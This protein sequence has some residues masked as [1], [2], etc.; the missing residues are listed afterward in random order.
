MN[1]Y[2]ESRANQLELLT[3]KKTDETVRLVNEQFSRSISYINS[4]VKAVFD[5]YTKNGGLTESQ[6]LKQLNTKQTAEFR[7]KLTERLSKA[8]SKEERKALIGLLDAPAYGHRISMLEALANEIYAEAVTIGAFQ[9][10]ALTKRLVDI[11]EQGYYRRTF[12]IQQYTGEYYDF[13]KISS[14]RLKA[15]IRE[16]WNGKNYSQRVWDNTFD[17]AEKLRDIVVTGVMTGQSYRTMTD[18]F[19]AVMGEN[20]DSGARFKA[21]RLIRT[22]VNYISGKATTKAYEQAEIDEYIYLATLDI[23]TC[24]DC[25]AAGRK[26]CAELDGKHFKVKEAKA[27]V[28]KHP[29]HP[30]CRCTD[31]P[32]IP[33]RKLGARAARDENGKSIQVPGDMTYEQWYDKY[34]KNTNFSAS[35][36]SSD[37]K[38]FELYKT[39]LKELCPK[40]I[41]EFLEIKYNKKDE[42]K[43]LN[44]QYRTV[45]QYKIDSGNVSV[46]DILELDKK[47]VYEKRNNFTSKYK[48]SGNVAGAYLDNDLEKF[49]LSHSKID[50]AELINKYRGEA[51]LTVLKDK[52]RF[53]YINV[54]RSDGNLRTDTHSDTEAKIFEKLADV[55]EASP[56]YSVTML[57]ERGM[58]DSCRG[59]ME[60]FK[61]KFP[62]VSVNVVSNKKVEGNVWKYRR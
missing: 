23:K 11:Y 59:V 18:S 31:C 2:W 57:S 55:Y 56:F 12:D 14:G 48:K 47:V 62:A 3:Q 58:C 6:A 19:I 36:S 15:A 1:D 22:E 29:M 25:G 43:K 44:R 60:Q 8:E 40:T 5:R 9:N 61:Q 46:R 38:Q 53:N 39:V 20:A 51:Q 54:V 33:G 42:W 30:F 17:T 34:G 50:N 49:Y 41:D 28:N 45:N 52:R 27:G 10:T 4:Q 16:P 35:A 21:S 32:Y 24:K 13:E 7:E 26:S 37:K